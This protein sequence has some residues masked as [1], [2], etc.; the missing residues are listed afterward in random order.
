MAVRNLKELNS[1]EEFKTQAGIDT[2]RNAVI[3]NVAPPGVNQAK[4]NQ[5]FLN[6]DWVVVANRLRYQAGNLLVAYPQERQGFMAQIWGDPTR[7]YGVGLQAFYHQTAMSFLNVQKRV[8]DEFLRGKGDYQIQKV[9]Q[10]KV[11]RP[12]VA[13]AANERWGM[14]LIDMSYGPAA[15]RTTQYILT[16]V[17]YFSGYVWARY[18]PSKAQTLA[19]LQNICATAPPTGANG[20]PRFLQSDNGTEFNNGPMTA[21]AQANQVQQIFTTTYSPRSNGKVERAN[22]EIRKKIKAGFLRQNNKVWIGNLQAYITNINSQQNCRSKMTSSSLWGQGY[23]PPGALPPAPQVAILPTANERAVLNRHYLID[24][25][26]AWTQGALTT[27]QVGDLVRVDMASLSSAYR[28]NVKERNIGR[29]AV[30]FS[31]VVSRILRVYPK[32]QRRLR[33]MYSITVG[34]PG[35]NPPAGQTNPL[36]RGTVP[37]LFAGNQLT[38]A[39]DLVTL[40]PRTIPRAD[41]MNS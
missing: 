41:W 25:A 33:E 17:D 12:I 22:H 26:E 29:H 34:T 39:G 10:R 14:D 16:V 19:Q 4:F 3:N 13:K 20:F 27:F 8:T 30:N 7:G 11:I 36:M 15:N 38:K 5:R 23:N 18:M 21:W 32:T 1:Y 40:N 9:P 24:R 6:G 28:K 35:Q 2:V 31:P 37:W